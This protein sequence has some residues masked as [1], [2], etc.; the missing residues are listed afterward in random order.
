MS[1]V[2]HSWLLL[3]LLALFIPGMARAQE[4]QPGLSWAD[5]LTQA[6]VSSPSLGDSARSLAAAREGASTALSIWKSSLALNGRYSGELEKTSVASTTTSP[7][8]ST[9]TAQDNTSYSASLSV[10][11]LDQVSIQGSLDNKLA[12]KLSATVQPFASTTQVDNAR[13][14]LSDEELRWTYKKDEALRTLRNLYASWAKSLNSHASAILDRD[15]KAR[16]LKTEEIKYEAGA[17]TS[18]TLEE[19]SSNYV[20]SF[21]TVLEQELAVEKSRVE[22][23]IA[24]GLD[25]GTK[26][27]SPELS[28]A[29]ALDALAAKLMEGKSPPRSSLDL[30]LAKRTWQRA[31]LASGALPGF[32]QGL[33]LGAGLDTSLDSAS[34][35]NGTWNA[36]VSFSL[37]A[38]TFNGAEASSRERILATAL[39]NY[40]KAQS[41]AAL[42]ERI[43]WV[44]LESARSLLALSKSLYGQSTVK[45]EAQRIMVDNG[46]ASAASLEQASASLAQAQA[47]FFGAVWDLEKALQAW[48]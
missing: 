16:A 38:D 22:L 12:V 5:L 39:A 4:N 1:L 40:R 47:N 9:S 23:L 17:S 8:A 18:S 2:R 30:E 29:D 13:N 10:K 15:I 42:D 21:K 6:R 20:K 7:G 44:N 31:E 14:S 19:A 43:A 37:G 24:A 33:S 41:Q 36:S 28:N 46:S 27:A 32:F 3:V 11:P 35:T 45:Y 25:L 26:L 34:K 48:D